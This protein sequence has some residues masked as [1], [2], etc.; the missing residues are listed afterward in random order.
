MPSE[1][2]RRTFI[3]AATATASLAM[4]VGPEVLMPPQPPRYLILHRVDDYQGAHEENPRLVVKEVVT[5]EDVKILS[6][7]D[8]VGS[9]LYNSLNGRYLAVK[10]RF[11][12][13]ET[14]PQTL[15]LFD[16]KNLTTPVMHLDL[17]QDIVPGHRSL[18]NNLAVGDDG[19]VC[20]VEGSQLFEFA[21]DGKH[22]SHSI[23]SDNFAQPR[24]TSRPGELSL[25]SQSKQGIVLST[26]SPEHEPEP[27]TACEIRDVGFEDMVWSSGQYGAL[28][29]KRLE[30]E[31]YEVWITHADGGVVSS[32]SGA[33]FPT[34]ST[35]GRY[36]TCEQVIDDGSLDPATIGTVVIDMDKPNGPRLTLDGYQSP[37]WLSDSVMVGRFGA[38]GG[39]YKIDVANLRQHKYLGYS[40]PASS[41]ERVVGIARG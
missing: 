11:E 10:E 16:V 32:I 33:R 34:F 30:R 27:R 7:P 14:G 19:T 38:T 28:S 20:V 6:T 35:D 18:V 8:S 23:E 21:L 17:D 29:T 25:I 2:T 40:L 13:D 15:S 26:F 22:Y 3:K 5:G 12:N 1:I 24:Y 37:L 31:H 36:M 9:R 4:L 39:V 41:H